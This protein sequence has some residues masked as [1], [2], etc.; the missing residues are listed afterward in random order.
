MVKPCVYPIPL[1]VIVIPN[2]RPLSSPIVPIVALAIA[3]KPSPLMITV[4]AVVYDS[5]ELIIAIDTILPL[6]T[7]GCAKEP[8]PELTLIAGSEV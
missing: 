7:I 4:G 3:P 2:T 5:P 1:L 6:I 8:S